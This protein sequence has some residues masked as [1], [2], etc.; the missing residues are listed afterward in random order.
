MNQSLFMFDVEILSIIMSYTFDINNDITLINS[1]SNSNSN[2]NTIG[3]D[4]DLIHITINIVENKNKEM[5]L[6]LLNHDK[7]LKSLLSDVKFAIH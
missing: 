7:Q 4:I 6:C 3:F 5:K 1:D 2:S